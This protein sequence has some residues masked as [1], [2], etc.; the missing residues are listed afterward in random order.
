[1]WIS[2]KM[3]KTPRTK[4][5]TIMGKINQGVFGEVKGKVGNL[6]GCT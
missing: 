6:V 2:T 3:H 5:K 1:M 4:N